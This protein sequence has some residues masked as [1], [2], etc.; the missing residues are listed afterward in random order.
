MLV[1]GFSVAFKTIVIEISFAINRENSDTLEKG[2]LLAYSLSRD[3]PFWRCSYDDT[4]QW[5]GHE[6]ALA[7]AHGQ[8]RGHDHGPW[9]WP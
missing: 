8:R 6:Q 3:G 5:H 7:I 1:V 4:M 2:T 9:S